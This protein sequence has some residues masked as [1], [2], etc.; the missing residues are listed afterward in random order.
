MAI[1]FEKNTW[2]FGY[3]LD[4]RFY[5]ILQRESHLSGIDLNGKNDVIS[6]F[7]ISDKNFTVIVELK[8]PNIPLYENDQNRSES[9]KL[10]K[11]ITYSISQIL[12]QKAEWQIKSENEN[13]DKDGKL[14]SLKNR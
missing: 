7:L 10:S 1:F 3:G 8:K 6:D 2:I 13:F 9:W 14:D 12:A 4:Y 5:H 11:D